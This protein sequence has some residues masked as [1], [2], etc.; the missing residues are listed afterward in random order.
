M[1]KYVDQLPLKSPGEM[2]RP[3]RIE[4]RRDPRCP[5]SPRRGAGF[6]HQHPPAGGLRGVA[7]GQRP[8][9]GD[10]AQQL[11]GAA[12]AVPP[13][14]RA[15]GGRHPGRAWITSMAGCRNGFP[16][17]GNC[18]CA[19]S[20]H[21]C[22]TSRPATAAWFPPSPSCARSSPAATRSSRP[23][24]TT[25]SPP[26]L[27]PAPL[28]TWRPTIRSPSTWRSATGRAATSRSRRRYT[29]RSTSKR[30]SPGADWPRSSTSPATS[31]PAWSSSR[32]TPSAAPPS[33]AQRRSPTRPPCARSRDGPPSTSASPTR[34]AA[35]TRGSSTR[36]REPTKPDWR[37]RTS[38]VS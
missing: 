27:S 26:L 20:G 36:S 17:G 24:P 16:T 10:D 18:G 7:G 38:W 1:A 32:S 29:S 19:R 12:P 5:R 13:R 28:P 35:P 2:S 23:P 21:G 33:S 15:G 3:V 22:C 11:S 6:R 37:R 14:P 4:F 30:S 25:R 31:S 9:A 34:R 8:A